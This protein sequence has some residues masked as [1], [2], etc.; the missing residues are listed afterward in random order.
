METFA[1]AKP[2]VDDPRFTEARI[3]ELSELE[4]SLIDAPIRDL[5]ARF[6]DRPCCFTLQ[7]CCG[8]FVHDAQSGPGNLA[9]L[10][11]HGVGVVDYR[12]AT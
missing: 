7:C 8:H 12:I 4:P 9:P 5:G 3:H 10:P 11:D 6:N 1:P 2:L